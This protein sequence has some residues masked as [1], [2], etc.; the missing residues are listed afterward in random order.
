[1]LGLALFFATASYGIETFHG[2]YYIGRSPVA[3][4]TW[5]PASSYIVQHGVN[6][7]S[8]RGRGMAGNFLEF[9][10][11]SHTRVSMRLFSF[12]WLA[13]EFRGWRSDHEWA[14]PRCQREKSESPGR[15]AASDRQEIASACQS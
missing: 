11:S 5:G 9:S 1:L 2:I 7:V 3:T 8:D 4:I 6:R 12:R 14:R 10:V 15:Q 13:E